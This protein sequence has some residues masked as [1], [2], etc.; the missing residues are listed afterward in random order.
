MFL[1]I[2]NMPYVDYTISSLFSFFSTSLLICRCRSQAI[3]NTVAMIQNIPKIP[4]MVNSLPSKAQP[5]SAAEIGSN[6]ESIEP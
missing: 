2:K 5:N 4:I 3:I 6:D 1:E